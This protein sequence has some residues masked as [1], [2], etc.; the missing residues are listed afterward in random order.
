MPP[1]LRR[2]DRPRPRAGPP[3]KAV[4]SGLAQGLLPPTFE[5]RRKLDATRARGFAALT[6]QTPDEHDTQWTVVGVLQQTHTANDRVLFIPLTSFYAIAEHEDA[7]A[8]ISAIRGG[9]STEDTPVPEKKEAPPE[10]P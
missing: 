8:T 9:G 3:C 7:M 5:R 2:Q 6:G 4:T 10:A 1:A